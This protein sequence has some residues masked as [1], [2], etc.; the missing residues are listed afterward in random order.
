MVIEE[1]IAV[2]EVDAEHL[3]QRVLPAQV[4]GDRR[5][6]ELRAQRDVERV[7]RRVLA[8]NR[9]LGHEVPDVA[10]PVLNLHVAQLGVLADDQ[11]DHGRG[12][13][14]HVLRRRAIGVGDERLG[15]FLE[16]GQGVGE[17]APLPAAKA[18]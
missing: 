6:R 13:R 9:A 8:E 16:D 14:L 3:G 12:E 11:L 17:D 1:L 7:E 15:A 10:A 5:L 4:R 18:G 2:A